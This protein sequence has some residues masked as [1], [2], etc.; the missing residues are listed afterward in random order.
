M[1]AKSNGQPVATVN[2]NVAS[3]V[4]EEVRA[5][6]KERAKHLTLETN[7]VL[8]LGLDSLERLQIASSLEEIFGGRLPEEVLANVDTC[9]EVAVAIEQYIGV[10][11][12]GHRTATATGDP[13]MT[14]R[15][16]D[17]EPAVEDYRFEALPEY[18]RLKMQMEQIAAAG[19]VNPYFTVHEG[20]TR[21]T[22]IVE[23]RELISFASYNYLGMS[24][25]PVVVARPATPWLATAPASRPAGWFPAR[26]P[27]HRQLERAIADFIGTEDAIVFVGGH[28]T[29][30]TTIGHLFGAG[31]LILH[32]ALLAQ[33]HHAGRHPFRGPAAPFPHNDCRRLRGS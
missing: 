4:L 16:A 9:R 19:G 28:S 6:A 7:I 31:D 1:L 30:E 23:G 13:E 24:G 32:D 15:P 11:P 5:M 27:L 8:D 33:Q 18:R 12:R 22:T 26:K 2:P 3:I 29:N 14:P 10:I 21:D 25:D 20:L 17:Y